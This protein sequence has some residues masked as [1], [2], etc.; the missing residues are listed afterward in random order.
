MII[1]P[2]LYASNFYDGSASSITDVTFWM[3]ANRKYKVREVNCR[4]AC[5][6]TSRVLLGINEQKMGFLVSLPPLPSLYLSLSPPII[7]G[8]DAGGTI[9]K[10]SSTILHC[11]PAKTVKHGHGIMR[12]V[13]TA[14]LAHILPTNR[15]ER[16]KGSAC[17]ESLKK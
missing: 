12:C 13:P 11:L 1:K 4:W 7:D 2:H 5:A 14:Q 17:A 16:T 9:F 10:A 8:L 15:H 3:A 6:S